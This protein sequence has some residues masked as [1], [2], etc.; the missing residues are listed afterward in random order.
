MIHRLSSAVAA[1]RVWITSKHET[2]L[3]FKQTRTECRMLREEIR[4][5]NKTLDEVNM[6][7]Q[8]L[9]SLQNDTDQDRMNKS[10]EIDSLRSELALAQRE[11]QGLAGIITR[12]DVFVDKMIA[13]DVAAAARAKNQ[14]IRVGDNI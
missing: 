3:R 6:R 13:Q 11:I 5:L 12:K 9:L 7:N 1:V 14:D 10:N 8:D 2:D 4:E